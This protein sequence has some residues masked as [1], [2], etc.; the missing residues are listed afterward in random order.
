M[1][2]IG[3]HYKDLKAYRKRKREGKDTKTNNKKKRTDEPRRRRCWDWMITTGNCHYA[4]NRSSFKEYRRVG[5][6]IPNGVIEG[7]LTFIAGVGSVELRVRTAYE[8][9]SSVRT[10]VLQDVLHIPV[11]LKVQNL[12]EK[13]SPIRTLVLKNVLHGLHEPIRRVRWRYETSLVQQMAPRN[14]SQADPTW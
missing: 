6:S 10:L 3:A 14:G 1:G 8:E 12:H 11:E 4:K 5:K 2:E 13:N 7:I 9:R